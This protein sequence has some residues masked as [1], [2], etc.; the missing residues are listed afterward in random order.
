MT[1]PVWI[2]LEVVLAIHDVQLAE[3]G[4]QAGV[5]DRGLLESALARPQNQ[6][7]YGEH[8]LPR[9]AASYAFGISRNHPFLDGNKRT[10]LV[11]AELFLDLNGLELTA[12]DAECVTTFLKLAAGE[13]TEEQLTDW[14]TVHST[15]IGK[16]SRPPPAKDSP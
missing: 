13:L 5:R 2:D 11:V 1:E 8:A 6:F 14:I 4:G 9:L 16:T 10:S 7:A 12:T 15:H 3:H